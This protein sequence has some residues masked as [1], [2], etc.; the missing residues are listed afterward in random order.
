M[1]GKRS[2]LY[3]R[4]LSLNGGLVAAAKP[5]GVRA[6]RLN[7]REAQEDHRVV[8]AK[9][10]FVLNAFPNWNGFHALIVHISFLLLLGAPFFVIVGAALSAP[11]RRWILGLALTLMVLGT[12]MI[13]VAVESGRATRK[14]VGLTP[15]LSVVVEEHQSLAERTRELFS[16]LTLGFAALFFAPQL[17]GRELESRVGTAL[18]AAFLLFYGSGAIF[19]VDTA[20]EGG[21]LVRELGAQAGVIPNN[22]I[23][24]SA[25]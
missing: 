14:L 16:V 4:D 21:R 15:E 2:I 12:A 6:V 7:H 9:G 25:R 18:L 5:K 13:F 1:W 8:W 24:V 11:K 22:P 10:V 3:K 23:Q 19:L 17:L 20:L